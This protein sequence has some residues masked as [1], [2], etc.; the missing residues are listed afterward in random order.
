MAI[1]LVTYVSE[2]RITKKNEVLVSHGVDTETMENIMLPDI[3]PEQIG[4]FNNRMMEW[5]MKE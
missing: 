2:N 1:V 3:P 4:Y 5:V